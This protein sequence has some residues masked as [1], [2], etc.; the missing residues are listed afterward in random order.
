MSKAIVAKPGELTTLIE[1]KGNE[2][3][4]KPLT[5]EIHLF[6]TF[7]AG[8]THLENP[9]IIAQLHIGESLILKREDNQFDEFA[10]AIYTLTKTRI[11]YIPESDN[12]IFA[13]LMDAGKKLGATITKIDKKGDF[14]LVGI[15]INL[16]DF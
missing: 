4:I 7:V 6:D 15:A 5:K 11:G 14:S 2:A 12:L 13:R 1:E 8:T 16:I 10:V 9:K 3:L